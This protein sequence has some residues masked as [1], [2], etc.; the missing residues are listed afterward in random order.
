VARTGGRGPEYIGNAV[1]LRRLSGDPA[2]TGTV[3][4]TNIL[5]VKLNGMYQLQCEHNKGSYAVAS[6]T[7]ATLRKY[8]PEARFTSFVQFSDEFAEKHDVRVIR[9]KLF[10]TKKYSL[11]TMV[12]SSFQVMQCALWALL[13]RRLPRLAGVLVNSRELK[14]YVNADVIIDIS[15]DLYCDT[16]GA[17]QVI[18]HSKEILIG[19]LLKKPVV[20]WAQSPGPFRSKLSSWLVRLALNRVALIMLRE[21]ISLDYVRE[22]GIKG[23]DIHITADPAFLLQPA[24]PDRGK[25]ILSRE[26]INGNDRPLV[27]LTLGWSNMRQIQK[28]TRWYRRWV[29]SVYQAIRIILPEGLPGFGKRQCNRSASPNIPSNA[30]VTEMAKI[31]DAIIEALGATV[32]LIPHDYNPVADDRNLAQGILRKVKQVDRAKLIAGGYS[33]PEIKSVIGLCDLFVGGK[34]HANIAATSMHVPTVAIQYGHK[35]YGIMR[36]LGQE[37]YVCHEMAAEEVRAKVQEAW[38]N[39]E[40]IRAELEAKTDILKQQALH[41]AE[42]VVDLLNGSGGRSVS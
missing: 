4:V 31:V 39:R 17:T 15:M 13:Q 12:K 30:T 18:E 20:I 38:S 6:A 26:G 8:F 5:I 23:P 14:E 11:G 3:T 36:S 41:N 40:R 19:A 1:N 37:K 10:A 27:G 7:V 9:N 16:G 25:E 35:F 33:A 21:E 28:G 22:L 34:M 24:S 29:K 42:L 2:K 32:V